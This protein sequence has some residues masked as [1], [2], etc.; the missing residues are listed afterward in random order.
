MYLDSWL[1]N[2]LSLC[3]LHQLSVAPPPW[4]LVPNTDGAFLYHS[5]FFQLSHLLVLL[6]HQMTITS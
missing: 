5:L 2:L 3:E 1:S 4:I 6:D